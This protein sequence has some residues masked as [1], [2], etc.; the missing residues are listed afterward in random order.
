[1]KPGIA[2]ASLLALCALCA[3]PESPPETPAGL[4]QA[5]A[6][7][8]RAHE[9]G[10]AIEL[11]RRSL[12]LRDDASVRANLA[13]ALAANKDFAGAATEYQRLLGDQAQNGTLWHEYGIVL[14][15][16]L[17]DLKG[18]EEA[19]F[20]ATQYPPKPAEASYD[21]G[22]VLM[23]R[24]RYEE[25]GACFDAAINLAPPKSSWL[26][27]AQARQVQAYLL[28]KKQPPPPR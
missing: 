2:A 24:G 15:T 27:D 28:A 13:H 23:Q 18:A 5:A 11:Y 14:E 22:R 6:E 12:A 1:M 21:L 8:H 26:E 17:R 9:F 4:A 19:L 10:K 16:G 7:Q 20:R 25:A 3:C